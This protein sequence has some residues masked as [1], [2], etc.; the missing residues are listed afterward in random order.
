MG[1]MKR[2]ELIASLVEA[3]PSARLDRITIY[4]DSV[5]DYQ[6]AT[7]NIAEHGNIVAHPRTGAPIDNHYIKVK[8]RAI[9][10]LNKVGRSLKTDML[11]AG[12][13]HGPPQ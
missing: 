7:K 1:Q 9:T 11:W 3:N 8:S 6:E 2:D 5:M 10:V 4:A 12:P 13:G